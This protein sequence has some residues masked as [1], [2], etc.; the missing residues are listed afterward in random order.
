MRTKSLMIACAI[1]AVL[2]GPAARSADLMQVYEQATRSDPFIQEAEQRRLAA[3]EAK[4]QARGALFPQI[5]VAGSAETIARDGSGRGRRLQLAR[6]AH[7]QHARRGGNRS[8]RS[9]SPKPATDHHRQPRTSRHRRHQSLPS[10]K[11]LNAP[12][13]RS[14]LIADFTRSANTSPD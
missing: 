11:L 7:R 3:L 4:P 14:T 6:R 10:G 5:G 9:S 12:Q 2:A 1:C 13:F 8:A